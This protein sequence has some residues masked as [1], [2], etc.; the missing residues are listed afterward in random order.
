MEFERV[1][2]FGCSW[3]HYKWPT[4]A[5]ICK[6]GTDRPVYNWGLRGIGNVG[7]L[8]RMIEAD[9]QHK[10]TEKDLILV[11]WSTWTREDRFINKWEAGGSVFNNNFYDKTFVKKYWSWNNDIIKNATAIISANKIFKISYQFTFHPFP[12]EP[13]FGVVDD[14]TNSK[15]LSLYRKNLPK[16]PIFPQDLNTDFNNTCIDGHADIG[17]HLAFFEQN[18][19]TLGFDIS[20]KRMSLLVLHDVIAHQLNKQQTFDQQ[21]KIIKSNVQQFDKTIDGPTLGF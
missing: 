8:H 11:Q 3:T 7:I 15:I 12:L 2:C 14:R 19:E 1:F 16:I 13:D 9:L 6:Y 18:I 21:D 5:D 17:A 10:F 4:W 20:K